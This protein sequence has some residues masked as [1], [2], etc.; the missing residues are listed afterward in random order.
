MK[1]FESEMLENILKDFE[2][3]IHKAENMKDTTDIKY[4]YLKGSCK[5]LIIDLNFLLELHKINSLTE[6]K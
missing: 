6:N 5:S 4:I 1:K 3:R 2:S